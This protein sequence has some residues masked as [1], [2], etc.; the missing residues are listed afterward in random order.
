M[1]TCG[2]VSI[3]SFA[4]ASGAAHAEGCDSLP[5]PS[6]TLKRFEVPVTTNFEYGYR[7]LTNIGAALADGQ[8]FVLGL[9]RGNAVVKVEFKAPGFIDRSGRYECLS[10]QL[11]L[12]YGFSPMTV[13]VAREFPAGTCAYKQIYE[14]ELRHVRTYLA[15]LVAIEPEIAAVLNQRFA[16]G[17]PWRGP[18]GQTQGRLQKELE[19]RWIPYLQREI[20]RVNADQRLIDTP[21]EYERVSNSCNGEI[22]KR[23]AQK[24]SR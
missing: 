21:E 6:V 11:T 19:E 2:F 5:L 7:T 14:H 17:A 12:S 20:N 24:A 22:S 10:P 13:Y 9:T 15:H 8:R 1:K 3:L 16:T 18:V 4:L 23:L